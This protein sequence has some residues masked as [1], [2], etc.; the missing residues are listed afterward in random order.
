[1]P[2]NG[3]VAL[4]SP[5]LNRE[6]EDRGLNRETNDLKGEQHEKRGFC[7]IGYC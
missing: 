6:T 2:K 4:V 7:R 1:M 5:A 3:I